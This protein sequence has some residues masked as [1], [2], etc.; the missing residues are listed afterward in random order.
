M[1]VIKEVIHFIHSSYQISY[2]FLCW[3]KL[4]YNETQSSKGW[5]CILAL[6]WDNSWMSNELQTIGQ[7]G[8]GPEQPVLAGDSPSTAGELQASCLKIEYI[9]HTLEGKHCHYE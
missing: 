6:Q 2:Q 1:N 8:W 5:I 7:V 9:Q 3:N 4:L